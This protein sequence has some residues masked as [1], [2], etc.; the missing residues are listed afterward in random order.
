MRQPLGNCRKISTF[1]GVL[2]LLGCAR[3]AEPPTP[4]AA[5]TRPTNRLAHESSP[6]LLQHAHNPVNWYPWGPDA[7]ARAK[8]E[9]KLIFLS[10]GYSSCHWCHVMERESFANPDVAKLLNQWFVCIKV[11]REERPDIDSIYMTA[12]NVL[13]KRGGWPLSMFLTP[14]GKP[15]IGGTYWPPEDRI[16]EGETIH[17]FKSILRIMN[18]WQTNK[19]QDLLDQANRVAARTN[20]VLSEMV[21]SRALVDLNHDLIENA[22]KDIKEEFDP[23]YGG[24][25]SRAA[26]FRGTKFPTP[27]YLGLLLYEANRDPSKELTEMVVT[28]LDHMAQGGIYDQLGGGFHR[29]STERTWTVPHFEK[30]LYDNAQ[31]VAVYARAFR[32]TGKPAYRR[33]VQETLDFIAHDLTAPGGGFYSALDAD[34]DG[35][36]GLY[37]LWTEADL[38]AALPERS[39]AALIRKVYGADRAPNFEGK[40]HILVLPQLLAEVAGELKLSE[41]QLLARLLP[42]RQKLLAYRARRPQPFLDTKILT[43][44]NGQMI[45]GYATAGK[46]LDEPKYVAVAA[47]AADFI[48]KNLR[49]PDGRLLR[50]FSARPG[51]KGTARLSGYLDDY[52]F[53]THGLLCLYDATSESRWLDEAQT[54]TD[55]MVRDFGDSDRGGFFYTS[56]QHEKLFARAKDQQDSVQPSGNSQAARNLVQLWNK[57]REA[58]YR[59]LAQKT[60]RAFAASMKTNPT[61]LTAMLEALDVSVIEAA[62]KDVLDRVFGGSQAN[63]S[64]LAQAGAAKKS[65]AV[66]QVT[67]KAEPDQPGADGKQVVSVT[68]QIDKGWH[69]YANPPGNE[70]LV[71][72]QTEVSVESKTSLK[73]VKV[74]YPKGKELKDDVLKIT[75][76]VYEDKVT[77]KATIQRAAGDTGPLEVTVKFQ[78]CN[79]S[80]CLLPATK[81]IKLE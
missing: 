58:R 23:N 12:L 55:T 20:V 64:P 65:D 57:T 19:R 26:H 22:I 7:F 29:Y 44:W 43:G 63:Q 9:N 68:L 73:D 47:R 41:E 62:K 69:A 25:G 6:Y 45:A 60:F 76:S 50:S 80:S 16:I 24:F 70:D 27:T 40:Y 4:Q 34:S 18:D 72:S 31:L 56:T 37:Y 53:F 48:L 35:G 11:D 13:G 28:T 46:L 5:K 54:L 77:I 81:K 49:T 75:Y 38:N 21:G 52:A 59:D 8:Q 66:I 33:I 39:E 74:E 79:A 32:L 61:S 30:M 42:L 14:D 10:I 17:G 71:S 2:V 1:V 3:A 67:A 78:A 36:E 51:E 15:I